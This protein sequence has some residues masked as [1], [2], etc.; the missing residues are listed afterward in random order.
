M[1]IGNNQNSSTTGVY[2]SIY[3]QSLLSRVLIW[4]RRSSL[5]SKPVTTSKFGQHAVLVQSEKPS[6]REFSVYRNNFPFKI[7][8]L[9]KK[10]TRITFH[11]HNLCQ[12]WWSKLSSKSSDC[13]FCANQARRE[14]RDT[15]SYCGSLLE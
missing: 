13:R 5:Q 2:D 15:S 12:N 9:P 1:K 11:H 4:C 3:E 6:I 14:T 10:Y 7:T 8:K